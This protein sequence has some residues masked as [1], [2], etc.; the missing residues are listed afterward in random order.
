MS[1]QPPAHGF[2]TFLIVWVTQSISVLGSALTFFAMTIWLTQVLYPRPE[3][4]PELARAL[5]AISLAFALPTVLMAPLAGAWADRH[6]R[7][8]TMMAADVANGCLSALLAVLVVSNTL[9]IGNLLILVIVFST[10][11]AFHSAAFDTSYAMIV[12]EDLLP[13][14]NGMMQTIWSLSGI[15]SPAIAAFIISLPALARQGTIPGGAG[16]AL[17][18]LQDGTALAIGLD[19]LTFF[20]AAATLV[21]L[22]IPSP[23]RQ[24]LRRT[25][26]KMQRS[27]WADMKEGA[28][29]IWHRRPLVWLLSTFAVANFVLSPIGVFQPLLVKFNLASDWAARGF[30]FEAALA[31]LGSISSAGGVVG[32]VFVSAWGGLQAR[33]VY[34]V[35]V[36]LIIAGVAQIIFGL[37]PSLYLA[38][39]AIFVLEGMTPLMNA[40]SQTIWQIQTPRELQGRV[41][42]V[43][44]L[45]A[46]FTWPLSTALA[47][48]AGGAFNPGL[49]MAVLGSILVVFCLA[50]LFNPHLLRV[51]DKAYLDEI[52]LRRS[53]KAR[54]LAHTLDQPG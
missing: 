6:D 9:N 39:L 3:Q 8:A 25:T 19:A 12:P 31:L 10:L 51:E 16:V 29:Y 47:G 21:F 28:L 46:Q 34:G 32:G 27:I 30:T 52:A 11:G 37:S 23:K 24:D 38:A 22:S 48:W 45:I 54:D 49:V 44:R 1:Y 4:K 14:A 33:R 36:P 40:H 13:R 7:K 17:A 18:R 5:S 2:R 26:G 43:R 50:Q 20:V 15:L 42:A 35:L 53:H 41:F